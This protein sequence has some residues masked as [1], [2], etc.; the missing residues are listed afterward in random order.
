M[1]AGGSLSNPNLGDSCVPKA[2]D[3]VGNGGVENTTQA[4]VQDTRRQKLRSDGFVLLKKKKKTRLGLNTDQ[5]FRN[6]SVQ[7]RFQSNERLY[8][9]ISQETPHPLS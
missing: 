9:L 1:F 4:T 7:V 5:H 3:R 8:S 2:R 6:S